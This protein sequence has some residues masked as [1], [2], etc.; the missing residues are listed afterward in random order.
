MALVIRQYF[1]E[2]QTAQ[3]IFVQFNISDIVMICLL[4]GILIAVAVG[5]ALGIF[6][7]G[8]LLA[9]VGSRMNRSVSS[10]IVRRIVA[11][12]VNWI[13]LWSFTC[14]TCSSEF[15]FRMRIQS[16]Q[17]VAHNEPYMY[18]AFNYS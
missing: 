11:E 16:A 6:L 15:N 4:A 14:S 13:Q 18:T 3:S 9:V 8:V 5:V 1:M 10:T 7:G 17:T 12:T 2:C